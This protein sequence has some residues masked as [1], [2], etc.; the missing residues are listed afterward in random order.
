[1]YVLEL[2]RKQ[3][4]KSILH[5]SGLGQRLARSQDRDFSMM[6]NPVKYLNRKLTIEHYIFIFLSGH[7]ISK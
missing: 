5:R 7:L 2:K 1:M 3:K 6:Q 4:K